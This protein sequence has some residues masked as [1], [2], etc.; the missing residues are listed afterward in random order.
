MVAVKSNGLIRPPVFLSV[1]VVDN[2]FV[3]M[4]TGRI[5]AAMLAA[6]E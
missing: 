6:V 2:V 4:S 3:M 1:G 5:V